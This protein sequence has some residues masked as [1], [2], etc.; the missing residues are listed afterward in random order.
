MNPQRTGAPS[1]VDRLMGVIDRLLGR[2]PQA[3]PVPVYAP[4]IVR[5]RGD[6]PVRPPA[7][8]R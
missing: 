7:T 5:V 8:R 1:F 3:R 2:E 6:H 4:V